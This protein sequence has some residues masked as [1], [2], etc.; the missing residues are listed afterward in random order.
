M[1]W[2]LLSLEKPEPES[3][4]DY[5]DQGENRRYQPADHPKTV[6]IVAERNAADIH[7]P[8]ARRQGCRQEYHRE[9]RE[10]IKVSVGFLSHLRPQL[11][12]QELTVL[13][14]LLSVLDQCRI[15]MDLAVEAVEFVGWIQ[16][17]PSVN[18]G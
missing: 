14:V 4:K 11:F 16:Y 7:A 9:H 18:S 15:A 10:Y 6:R 2:S 17:R 5:R 8:D 3:E 12:D 13:R 1:R